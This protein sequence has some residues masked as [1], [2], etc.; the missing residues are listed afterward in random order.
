MAKKKISLNSN[1]RLQDIFETLKIIS[2]PKDDFMSFEP[3]VR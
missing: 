2:S 1:I 3:S